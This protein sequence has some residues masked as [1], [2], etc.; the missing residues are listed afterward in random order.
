MLVNYYID[1]K[2]KS[3]ERRE[4]II[5][6]GKTLEKACKKMGCKFLGIKGP[7]NDK[8]HFVAMIDADTMDAGMRP[9]LETERPE[10]LYHVEFKFYGNVYPE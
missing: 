5:E 2:G 9:F 6:Y 3:S 10:E 8:Y 7:A 4:K 1:M